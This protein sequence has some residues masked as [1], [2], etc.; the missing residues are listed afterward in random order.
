[1]TEIEKVEKYAAENANLKHSLDEAK[2]TIIKLQQ[3]VV[4][5]KKNNYPDKVLEREVMKN[6]MSLNGTVVLSERLIGLQDIKD[7]VEQIVRKE[8]EKELGKLKSK[9]SH[10]EVDIADYKEETKIAK[11][12]YREL[13]ETFDEKIKKEKLRLE[14]DFSVRENKLI[15]T[16]N[17]NSHMY[18][19]DRIS[20]EKQLDELRETIT[21]KDNEIEAA[22]RKLKYLKKSVGDSRELLAEYIDILERQI[23]NLKS[24]SAADIM[25]RSTNYKET[26]SFQRRLEGREAEVKVALERLNLNDTMQVNF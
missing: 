24:L 25:F 7:K 20:F 18:S 17:E 14:R 9:I 8:Y 12:Q 19:V 1:M 15:M 26:K 3:E 16:M 6:G 10:L 5:A 21:Q 4:E 2:A 13:K 11:N 22:E 23:R